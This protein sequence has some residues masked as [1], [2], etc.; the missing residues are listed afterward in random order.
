MS[1]FVVHCQ[2]LEDYGHTQEWFKFKSGSTVV[3]ENCDKLEN[4]I[5]F[6]AKHH[7][8][9]DSGSPWLSF[10]CSWSTEAEWM[11][12]LP[13]DEDYRNHLLSSAHKHQYRGQPQ[14]DAD[15]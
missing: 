9:M 12:S 7:C 14:F 8:N 4:A 13:D 1:T 3:V 15:E 10:P 6:V 5:A 2:A 11:A